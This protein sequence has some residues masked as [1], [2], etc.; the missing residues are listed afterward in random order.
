MKTRKTILL[1]TLFFFA[2]NTIIAQPWLYNNKV[3]KSSDKEITFKESQAA[4]YEYFK[5][6]EVVNAKGQKQ[7]KRWEFIMAPR[8]NNTSDYLNSKALWIAINDKPSAQVEDSAKWEFVGPEKTPYQIDTY[9]KTGNGRLNCVAF[10]P[11]EP[12]TLYV[13]APSGGFWKSTD[14]GASWT[15]TTD[16]LDAIGISDIVVSHE[17][18]NTIYIATGDGDA[19]DAYSIGILKST[20]GGATWNTTGLSIDV[21]DRIYFRRIVMHPDNA[22]IMF[23]GAKDGLYKTTDGWNTYSKIISLDIKD[24]EFKPGN[25]DYI[26]ACSYG[27]GKTK[28]YRSTNG[29]NTFSDISPSG[30]NDAGRVEIAV[31]PA[32]PEYLYAVASELSEDGLLSLHVSTNSGSSWVKQIGNQTKNLLGWAL[33]G[34][35]TDGQGWY[36]LALAVSPT[37]ETE[38]IVGG[39]NIWKSTNSGIDW[40]ISSY[41][42]PRD[43]SDNP[44]YVHADQHM[45]AYSPLTNELFAA[46]DGGLYKSPDDGDSW[47]DISNDLQ[48]LQSYKMGISQTSE[49]KIITGNQ[50]NGTFLQ[51]NNEW[52]EVYGGDGMQCHIDPVNDDTIYASIYY[53]DIFKSVNGGLTFSS[54]KP[55]EAKGGA[56]VTPYIIHPTK[57]NIIYAGYN[58]IFKSVDRGDSWEVISGDFDPY[59]TTLEIAVSSSNDNYIYASDSDSKIYK[60][61]NGGAHWDTIKSNDLPSRTVTSICVSPNDHNEVWVTYS[62]YSSGE[63]VFYTNDGGNSWANY[64][65]GLPNVPA[66]EIMYR[67]NSNKELY[68]ATDIGVYYRHA[69]TNKWISYSN[70]LPN[71]IVTDL[72]IVEKY[73]K[74]RAATY[75][76]GVWETMLKAPIPS[77][78]AIST[79]LFNGCINAPFEITYAGQAS[80]DSLKWN[81]PEGTI[82]YESTDKDTII[83]SFE[84]TGLK[85]VTLNHY[86][87]GVVSQEVNTNYL[88]V[89][90]SLNISLSSQEIFVCNNNEMIIELPRGYNY[91]VSPTTDVVSLE[92]NFLTVS[93]TTPVEYTITASHGTCSVDKQLNV[94]FLP[95]NICDAV[96]LPEGLHG[97]YSNSCATIQDHEPFAPVG[98]D[99]TSSGCVS[100]DGWCNSEDIAR[101]SVWFKVEVSE[102]GKLQIEVN[103]FDSK[104]ALYKSGSCEMLHNGSFTI[105]AANDDISRTN[106][107]SR[108]NLLSDLTPGDTLY[109]Q[110]DGSYGGVKGEF[111]VNILNGPSSVEDVNKDFSNIKVFPNPANDELTV[112]M[113]VPGTSTVDVDFFDETGK[114]ILSKPG[115]EELNFYEENFNV[116]GLHGLYFV[117]IKTKDQVIIRKVMVQ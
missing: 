64:S 44:D 57:P 86:H 36:D 69:D 78:T 90:S 19:G 38:V 66:N 82:E 91:S 113:I 83:V 29:G 39:V 105:L 56:W 85:T 102:S 92:N 77:K 37:D 55:A 71:V 112:R 30:Y 84:T 108:I 54:I 72:E 61:A 32:N 4:F 96:Y 22:D 46:N 20:D 51:T 49:Y 111:Y 100:Q 12:N 14:G 103:G 40:T 107:N 26:Y 116:S 74:L 98:S 3:L 42:T 76:R 67:Q 41:W 89:N 114:L 101:N 104:I 65:E 48:I 34:S 16:K 7:F 73:G 17:N 53:G 9:L 70:G 18:P 75:G 25:P 63:K 31:S 47:T 106:I 11:T 52:F 43:P 110:V 13:G 10:H 58:R 21:V 1:A 24:I 79:N 45:F 81:F 33:D 5:D 97:P 99:A 23:A 93:P 115:K 2:C 88:E 27:I 28:V 62:G 80:Y 8:L 6:K 35:D 94:V 87:E 15:T 60:T 50:D 95:D 109:L 117:R 59:S 68:L